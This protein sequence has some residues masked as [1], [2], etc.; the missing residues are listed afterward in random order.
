ML[1][2]S[3]AASQAVAEEPLP[4]AQGSKLT[5]T[6]DALTVQL[7]DLQIDR[8]TT[9]RSSLAGPAVLAGFGSLGLSIG[10]VFFAASFA[11]GV[12][13]PIAL[14]VSLAIAGASVLPLAIGIVWLVAN[15]THN[16]R[17]D[18]AIED[19]EDDRAVFAPV[20]ALPTSM[21]RLASF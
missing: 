10:A 9:K 21:F 19:L 1:V 4:G 18:D 7:I 15:L 14:I 12:A 8:L 17:I 6:A 5:L 13:N 20:S 3:L 2:V 11:G 16:G